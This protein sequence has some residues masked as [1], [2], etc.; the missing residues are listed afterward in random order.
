MRVFVRAL[1]AFGISEKEIAVMLQTNPAKLM[2]LDD[3]MA[4]P[5]DSWLKP[6]RHAS[7]ARA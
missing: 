6:G 1:L 3:K 5:E 2:Y 7:V 4:R